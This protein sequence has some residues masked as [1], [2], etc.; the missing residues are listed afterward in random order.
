MELADQP[1]VGA[2]LSRTLM[3]KSDRPSSGGDTGEDEIVEQR[4]LLE[5]DIN[6]LN[7]S[8]A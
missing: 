3:I 1:L 4:P 5:T 7:A 6:F 2:V 8:C